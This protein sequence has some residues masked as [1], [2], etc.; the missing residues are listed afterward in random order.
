MILALL[1]LFWTGRRGLELG[2]VDSL[3]DMRSEIKK[4]YGRDVQAR[5]R[6]R[7]P[8]FLRPSRARSGVNRSRPTA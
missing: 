2:L 1:G 3:G 7:R 4:R 8:R 5:T 6:L